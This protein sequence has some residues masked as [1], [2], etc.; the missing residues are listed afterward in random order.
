V[1]LLDGLRQRGTFVR[2]PAIIVGASRPYGIDL[3]LSG[4][5]ALEG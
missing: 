1:D 5:D 4:L 3:D 2:V